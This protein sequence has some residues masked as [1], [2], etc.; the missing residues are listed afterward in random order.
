MAIV[1]IAS[2]P[3]RPGHITLRTRAFALRFNYRVLLFALFASLVLLA[4]ATWAMSLGSFPI[5]F[6]DVVRTIIGEGS[7][8]F[9]FIVWT[10]RLPRVLCAVFVGA[11]L[12]ISGAIFQGLVR[13]PLVSPDI[14]G[15]DAGATLFAV[16]WIVSGQ[17]ST[18]LPVA[19]FLGA[20]LA[21]A[22]VYLLSWR[23]GIS[24]N[25]LILVGIGVGAALAAGTTYLM[26]RFP[27]EFVTAAYSWTVGSVYGSDWDDVRVVWLA[28]LV[29]APL[30][31]VLTWPLRAMQLGDDVT[32][33]LGL[34]LER[35]RLGL[36]A[37]GCA[38]AAVSVTVAGPVGF[39]ALMVPHMARMLA[40]PLSGSVMVLTAVLGACF[41][42]SADIVA[43][44]LLPV[45]LPVG[46]V[47]AAVGAPYFLFLLYR[48]GVR[49]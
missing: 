40:G 10:L 28:L 3:R 4:V 12:A 46:V 43:Q 14:I 13:N 5:P 39:V 19:A 31:V 44:H 42:L 41:L 21:A 45:S 32:R 23:G 27:I 11:A 37:V 2:S 8:E 15:I 35:T 26:V 1:G 30:A 22:L 48:A 20:I 34:P 18:L 47:T 24:T 29:L 6:A 38:L 16:F 7:Q 33:G 49:M 9:E 36:I 17:S 25:R